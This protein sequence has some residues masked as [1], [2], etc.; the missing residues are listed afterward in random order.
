MP[1]Y[2]Y[3]CSRGHVFDVIVCSHTNRKP[4]VKCGCGRWA[5]YSEAMTLKGSR[6]NAIFD[7]PEQY[8]LSFGRVIRSRAHLREVIARSQ[9]TA[10]PI[11]EYSRTKERRDPIINKDP[12]GFH[13]DHIRPDLREVVRADMKRHIAEINQQDQAPEI[14]V[15]SR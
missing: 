13:L 3:H 7:S 15:V 8:S 2:S 14:K 1:S 11:V 10:N 6:I 5:N 12:D 9:D 4:R